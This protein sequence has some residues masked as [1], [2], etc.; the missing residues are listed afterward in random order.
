MAEIKIDRSLD[1]VWSVFTDVKTWEAWWGGDL[2]SVRPCWQRGATLT[3]ANGGDA[4]VYDFVEKDR[5][6]VSGSY[7]EQVIWTFRSPAAGVTSVSM[8]ENLSG[9]SLVATSAA[10][11]EGEFSMTLRSLKRCVEEKYSQS[12]ERILQLEGTTLD[13]V[14]KRINNNLPDGY[15]VVAE[16]VLSDGAIK[17]IQGQGDTVE[18]AFAKAKKELQRNLAVENVLDHKVLKMPETTFVQV[19]EF[20]QGRFE[21]E[22]NA[23]KQANERFAHLGTCKKLELKEQARSGFFGIGKKPHKF[24]AEMFNPALVELTYKSKAVISLT[25][26][27]QTNSE[28][29]SH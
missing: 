28:G 20:P 1:Q 11:R 14:K 2:R 16:E 6:G 24:E 21:A 19:E 29:S 23:R 13:E 3:W 22:P 8:G 26:K 15:R 5:V 9:S 12:D 10:A 4:S 18:E 25:I 17:S 27:E 7:G